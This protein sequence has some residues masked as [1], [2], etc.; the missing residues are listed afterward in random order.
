VAFEPVQQRGLGQSGEGAAAEPSAPGLGADLVEEQ[1]TDLLC[2]QQPEPVDYQENLVVTF[3]QLLGEDE[4]L[5]LAMR[6]HVRP[7]AE[8]QRDR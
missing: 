3:A 1:A 4:Q 6:S 7:P 8:R 2:L 5:P